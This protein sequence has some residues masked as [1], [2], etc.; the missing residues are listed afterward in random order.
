MLFFKKIALFLLVLVFYCGCEP[1]DL[2]ELIN[3]PGIRSV[4]VFVALCDNENQGIVPV[5]SHLGNGRDLKGNLYWGSSGGVK[6]FMIAAQAGNIF[7]VN[8]MSLKLF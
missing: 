8:M 7:T 1:A 3:E 4:H 6:T 5:P 2:A